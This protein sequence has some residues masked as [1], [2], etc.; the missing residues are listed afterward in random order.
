MESSI[1]EKIKESAFDVYKYDVYRNFYREEDVIIPKDG[2]GIVFQ[3]V[4]HACGSHISIS[5]I[6]NKFK[7]FYLFG[8]GPLHSYDDL[9]AD[10]LSV[11]S[12][13]GRSFG[14]YLQINHNIHLIGKY[15]CE[16]DLFITMRKGTVIQYNGEL[17]PLGEDHM[18]INR[19]RIPS[20]INAIIYHIEK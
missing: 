2:K 10:E 19:S 12:V 7:E 13:D 9:L 6:E 17:F 1:V 11:I 3:D 18:F 16:K 5:M 14:K 15:V 4:Q 8:R 20:G